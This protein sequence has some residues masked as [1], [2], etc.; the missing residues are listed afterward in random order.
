MGGWTR[1]CAATSIG[2]IRSRNEDAYLL[3]PEQRLYAVADGMGGHQRGDVA[4]NLCIS[5]L[6]DWFTGRVADEAVHPL[7]QRV[8]EMFHL[9]SR[10][11]ADLVAAVEFANRLIYDMAF[12]SPALR[13]MGTTLVVAY[14]H[15]TTLFVAY[16]GDSRIYRLRKGRLVQLSV[17]HSLLNE[18]LRLRMIRPSE[19]RSFPYKNVIMKALGLTDRG[20]FDFFTRRVQRDDLYLLC[21]DG[22]TDMVEDRDIQRILLGSGTLEERCHHLVEA[23]EEAGGHDNITAVL[24][25]HE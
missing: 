17:D 6:R 5:A 15:G 14:F 22:L 16:S 13:G 25:G 12:E 10:G 9:G 11:E 18:Y 1:A 21:S 4:A 7:V 8:R 23:A 24:V 19:A 20:A 3:L 2:R